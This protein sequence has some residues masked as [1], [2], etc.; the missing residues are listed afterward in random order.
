MSLKLGNKAGA[1]FGDF[2]AVKQCQVVLSARAI[3]KKLLNVKVAENGLP[4][5]N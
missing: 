3:M 1:N 2:L 4:K 5:M